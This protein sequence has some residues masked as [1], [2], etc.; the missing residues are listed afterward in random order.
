VD[1]ASLFRKEL[2]LYLWERRNKMIDW[3][4]PTAQVTPH[5][6]VNDALMLH[7][8][9]KLATEEDGCNFNR[10]ETLC[11]KL[12]EIR[13]LLNCPMNVHCMFRSKEYNIEQSI[14]LPT[15]ADVHSMSLACD[16]DCNKD[17]SIQD[18]KDALESQLDSLG[19]RMEKGTTTW[20]HV[21]LHSV[22]PSGR[23]FTP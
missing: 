12:E 10:L 6:I 16:F 21:D 9:N 1:F 18:V 8:W 7:N 11:Q 14:L 20:V 4:D 5:F 23:Y 2:L 3:T 19:I 22:G 17:M 13:T 15:G